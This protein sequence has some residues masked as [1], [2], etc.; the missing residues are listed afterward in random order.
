M[1][2]ELVKVDPKEFGLDGTQGSTIEQAF[3]PKI[4][5]RDGYAVIYEQLMTKELTKELCNEAGDLRKKLVKVRTGIADIHKTQKAFFLSAGRF[6]DAWK[7]KETLPIEQMEKSL[8][9]I[10]KHFEKLESERIEKLESERIIE[11]SKYSDVFPAGLGRMDETVYV[12]YLAGLKL[13]YD[14]RIKAEKEAESE[15][16]RLIEVDKENERLKA[17]ED[18]RIRKE[19]AK[20]KAEADKREKEIEAERKANE[21]KIA[22][23]RSKAKAAA[24]LIE[25]ENNAKLKAEADAKAKLKA[26]LDARELAERNAKMEKEVQERKAKEEADKLAKA[27]IKKQ[28][29]IWVDSFSIS[30]IN[31]EHEKKA[32]INEKF[33][34]FKKWAKNEVESI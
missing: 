8:E 16:L 17:I 10:E 4:I 15:R 27:P 3:M 25:A 24:D 13:A 18:D 23:E 28:L 30:E 7:N 20:L 9:S 1:N 6:V 11:I 29:S 33:E 21:Q 34:A 22:E 26:E 2:T 5:E 32:L 31:F 14:E 12:N 19:N